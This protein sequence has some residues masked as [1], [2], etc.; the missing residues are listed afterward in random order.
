MTDLN[1]A[2]LDD[3]RMTIWAHLAELRTRLIRCTVAIVVGMAFGFW[4]YPYLLDVLLVPFHQLV[5]PDRSLIATDPLDPFA[6]RIKISAYTG[7][8]VAM[9]VLLWQVWRFVTPGLYPK[10]KRYAVPFVI[11]ALVLFVFGA[12]IA[13][14]TL[15]PTLQFLISIAGADVEPYYTPD[16]YVSLIA[17]MMLAFG[18]GFQFPVLLVALQ[19]AGVL[20][21]RKLIGWWRYAIVTITIVAAVITPSGDP[22]SMFALAIPMM[23]LY[24]I[25]V[26]IGLVIY[27]RKRRKAA[28]AGKKTKT[29]SSSTS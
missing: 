14:F 28:K 15:N 21:P 5:G 20:T 25:A 26:V 18:S 3:G 12:A 27:R 9:P 2:A 17:L 6:T 19:A 4:V 1:D 24:V 13:Y 29:S 22:V 11:S 10:E 23:L 7:V 16:N 8:V